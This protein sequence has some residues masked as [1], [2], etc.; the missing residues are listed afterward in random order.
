MKWIKKFW[1]AFVAAMPIS[2][3]A[4]A[5]L[6]LGVL[7]AGVGIIGVSI[8]RSVSPVDMQSAYNF[9]SSCWT[10]QIFSDVM[11][12]MSNLL[13]GVYKAIGRVTIPMAATL[14]ALF[15]AW[16]LAA[17]FFNGKLEEASKIMGN[18]NVYMVRF[19]LLSGLLL[20][21]LPRL[22][23]N[24]FIEPALSIGTSF[25]YIV[26]DNNTFSECMIASAIA[27][28]VSV[29]SGAAEYGA[30]HQK[31]VINWRVKLQIFT[32]SQVWE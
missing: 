16:R 1:I 10:C 8:W 31:C 30:F 25:D 5:P 22:I 28:P 27:D 17:G 13:P 2:A 15:I 32:K 3:G 7:G 9:F 20:M 11:I 23:T 24:I 19:A 6:V 26:S 21:P 18:F 29:S 14:L 4:I 12:A